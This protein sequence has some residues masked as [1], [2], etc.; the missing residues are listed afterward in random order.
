MRDDLHRSFAKVS[1]F[2]QTILL[3]NFTQVFFNI[4]I[5]IC[6]F[7]LEERRREKNPITFSFEQLVGRVFS[8]SSSSSSSF[9]TKIVSEKKKKSWKAFC[10]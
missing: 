8:K 1:H 4:D 6:L 7:L 3:I 5:E 2:N 10:R 9:I